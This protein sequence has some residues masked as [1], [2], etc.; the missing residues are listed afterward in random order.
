MPFSLGKGLTMMRNPRK[1]VVFTLLISLCLL[2][3]VAKPVYAA[4]IT[5]VT[6]VTATGPNLVAPPGEL[7]VNAADTVVATAGAQGGS[8]VF[9]DSESNTPILVNTEVDAGSSVFEQMSYFTVATASTTYTVTATFTGGQTGRNTLVVQVYRGV[10]SV[11]GNAVNTASSTTP[12]VVLTTAASGDYAVAGFSWRGNTAD[13]TAGL[14]GNDRNI[15]ASTGT[16][17]RITTSGFDNTGSTSVTNTECLGGSVAWVAIAVDLRSTVAYAQSLTASVG[18][19]SNLGKKDSVFR[20]ATVSLTIASS[21]TEH[22]SLFR[23]LSASLNT[24]S[25]F[26]NKDTLFRS[27]TSSLTAASALAE[28]NSIFRTIADSIAFTM[29]MMFTSTQASKTTSISCTLQGGVPTSCTLN[30]SS[31]FTRTSN[32]QMKNI[33]F[34]TLT[35]SISIS[36]SPA[37]KNSLLRALSSSLTL[38]SSLIHHSSLFR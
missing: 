33:L 38:A 8:V 20:A 16:G 14:V 22:I 19:A 28:K 5:F 29:R 21:L 3:G 10:A 34:R 15:Q 17:T 11:G 12:N 25:N 26:A 27:L 4:P 2:V 32:L 37:E 13:C 24:V 31:A 35:D 36:G 6:S 23:G 9:T 30:P 7:G 1:R 18:M